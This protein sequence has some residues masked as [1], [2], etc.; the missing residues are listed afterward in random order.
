MLRGMRD[1]ISPLVIEAIGNWSA[2]AA[3]WFIVQNGGGLTTAWWAYVAV[4][5]LTSLAMTWRKRV[6]ARKVG[7][8]LPGETLLPRLGKRAVSAG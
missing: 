6:R 7:A 8:Y 2:V 4:A 1:T 3:V 5:P